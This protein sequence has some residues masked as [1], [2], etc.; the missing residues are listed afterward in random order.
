M[1]P[2]KDQCSNP[3]DWSGARFH[4]PWL[5]AAID[6]DRLLQAYLSENPSFR[7]RIARL[8]IAFHME[9][10]PSAVAFIRKWQKDS[11][12]FSLD[13][14]EQWAEIFMVMVAIGFFASVEDRYRMV[15]PR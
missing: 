11:C 4:I 15:I 14:R 6:C 12:S 13:M 9:F 10:A 3:K 7:E 5:Q 1:L 2:W 8:E